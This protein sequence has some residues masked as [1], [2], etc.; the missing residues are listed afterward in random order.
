M[1]APGVWVFIANVGL[2][3]CVATSSELTT[4]TGARFASTCGIKRSDGESERARAYPVPLFACLRVDCVY[5]LA[6][7]S[8]LSHLQRR[9]RMAP[10]VRQ[11]SLSTEAIK[12]RSVCWNNVFE[13]AGRQQQVL[14][15]PASSCYS[16]PALICRPGA[17]LPLSVPPPA[18]SA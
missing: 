6:T 14:G 2:H 3:Q 13:L 4:L 18:I 7:C 1:H 12:Q 11:R 16:L 5:V 8:P 15:G 10:A 9:S 17:A